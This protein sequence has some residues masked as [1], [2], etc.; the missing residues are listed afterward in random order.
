VRE[1]ARLVWERSDGER[2]E[3]ALVGDT[4]VVGRGDDA[5][6]CIDEPLVSRQHARL[7]RRESGWVV[8]DLGSTNRTRVN[9]DVVMRDRALAHG[10]ELRFGR[11]RCLYQVDRA[12]PPPSDDELGSQTLPAEPREGGGG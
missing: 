3:F 4:L 10:D 12:V 2:V 1:I 9:G 7:E 6:I 8:V 5:S 11:A